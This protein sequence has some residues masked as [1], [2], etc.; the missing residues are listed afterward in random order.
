[1]KRRDTRTL[2]NLIA[3]P[4]FHLV[5]Q[6]LDFNDGQDARRHL[7][8]LA[9]QLRQQDEYELADRLLI[10]AN[11]LESNP[12]PEGVLQLA[13]PAFSDEP[14]ALDDLWFWLQGRLLQEC[15]RH[16]EAELAFERA[17]KAAKSSTEGEILAARGQF[18][19]D[20][21]NDSL[22][23]S[24]L[25]K[26][27]ANKQYEIPGF[28]WRLLGDLYRKHG[29][30]EK[31]RQAYQKAQDLQ[32]DP[33]SS[34]LARARLA[35]LQHS[36]EPGGRDLLP[37]PVDPGIRQTV[38][39][40]IDETLQDGKFSARLKSDLQKRGERLVATL[41]QNTESAWYAGRFSRATIADI[42]RER[43]ELAQGLH[44]GR[45]LSE[46]ISRRR[47]FLTCLKI[48][49][50]G[51]TAHFKFLDPEDQIRFINAFLN[52][53]AKVIF[54]HNGAIERLQPTTIMAYFGYMYNAT[55]E[56]GHRQ[57]ALDAVQAAFAAQQELINFFIEI[58]KHFFEL[59]VE[60][61]RL[62]K[63]GYDIKERTL[64]LASGISTG[65]VNFGELTVGTH[66][67]R[68]MVGHTTN[69]AHRLTEIARPRE[70]L[71]SQTSYD[72]LLP[73]ARENYVFEDVTA[74]FEYDGEMR[75]NRLKDYENRPIYLISK[76]NES[77]EPSASETEEK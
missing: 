18:E 55:E 3:K 50:R 43:R 61:I 13:A 64:G 68:M 42:E 72:L 38:Q 21:G 1:M 52:R 46:Q 47:Q 19:L 11:A 57:S 41:T 27:V 20:R 36:E 45:R 35:D 39:A 60:K 6:W 76:R 54:Q 15:Q 5:R 67:E 51:F 7:L 26:A 74:Q 14:H 24:C 22:A 8:Q 25:Q 49:F 10:L 9:T 48:T 4:L 77:S 32:K 37:L 62:E 44:Q 63:G 59:P 16:S 17:Q 71:T 12:T 69:I 66:S 30:I 23:E 34:A 31:A 75:V 33:Y 53:I 70:V 40:F 56:E 65:W 2:R 28:A 58:K 29:N 73:V